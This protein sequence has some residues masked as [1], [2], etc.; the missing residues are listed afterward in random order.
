MSID[1]SIAYLCCSKVASE[2]K[3]CYPLNVFELVKS[4]NIKIVKYSQI[5]EALNIPFDELIASMPEYGL[6]AEQNGD[7]RILYNDTM[8]MGTVR[9]TLL[10]ELGH[11]LM[12]HESGDQLSDYQIKEN[13]NLANCFARNMIAPIELCFLNKLSTPYAISK[14]F[15]MSLKAGKVRIDFICRDDYHINQL[16]LQNCI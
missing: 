11:F 8:E 9:F 10:H 7:Y 12:G 15:N 2:R 13:E 16:H 1:Y 3:L 5:A 6:L 14:Y 4:Y